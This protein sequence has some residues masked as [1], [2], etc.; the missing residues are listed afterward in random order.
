M[1]NNLTGF[2]FI[3]YQ[4]VIDCKNRYN[5]GGI[6]SIKLLLLISILDNSN[7][8]RVTNTDLLKCGLFGDHWLSK[9]LNNLFDS[10]CISFVRK[11]NYKYWFL[12]GK[13][14]ECCEY[15]ELSLSRRLAKFNKFVEGY[16]K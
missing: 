2:I 7:I 14:I 9:V 10:G 15:L 12:T 8:D 4:T 5:I 3:P 11:R 13:G 16:K 6:S 1:N